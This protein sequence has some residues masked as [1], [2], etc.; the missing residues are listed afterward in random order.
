MAIENSHQSRRAVFLKSMLDAF[1]SGDSAR[2]MDLANEWQVQS[3]TVQWVVDGNEE[4]SESDLKALS[5]MGKELKRLIGQ[6]ISRHK[7]SVSPTSRHEEMTL[8]WENCLRNLS[9][10]ALQRLGSVLELIDLSELESLD[11]QYAHEVLQILQQIVG[12]IG[13]LDKLSPLSVP[14]RAVQLA[15]EEAH[16]CFLFGFSRACVV[17]CRSTVEA[18]LREALAAFGETRVTEDTKLSAMLRFTGAQT[19]LQ[20]LHGSAN[21]VR[22]AGNAAVHANEA[23]EREYSAEKI[24]QV[25]ANTRKIVE[26]IY[27]LPVL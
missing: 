22:L 12:R 13:P 17:L 2:M 16:R 5:E 14:N 4:L 25:V 23:F 1:E 6:S 27:R 10:R 8:L 15:F 21:E 18:A 3:W 11:A 26:R 19:V 9:K 7:T 20:E 24:Q